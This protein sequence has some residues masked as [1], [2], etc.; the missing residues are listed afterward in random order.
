MTIHDLLLVRP[1]SDGTNCP[2]ALDHAIPEVTNNYYR[3]IWEPSNR[4]TFGRPDIGVR[5]DRDRFPIPHEDNRDNY[6]PDRPLEYWVSGLTDV[7]TL[8]SWIEA[9]PGFGPVRRVLDFGSSSGRV[10]RHWL[11]QQPA[12]ELFGAD[13]NTRSIAWGRKHLP[14]I[15][16]FNNTIVPHLPFPDG[17]FD[18]ITAYSV[19]T[20]IDLLEETWLLELRRISRPGGLVVLTNHSEVVWEAIDA[21]HFMY[22]S[23]AASRPTVPLTVTPELFRQPMPTPRLGFERLE[24]VAN[25]INMFRSRSY[26]REQWGRLFEVRD[27]LERGHLFHDLVILSAP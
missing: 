4:V 2:P 20:H 27:I 5:M 12:A 25:E 15:Y 19:F 8:T 24:G 17:Y 14:G 3:Y 6:F 23:L 16:F 22:E 1:P 9:Q 18:L 7:L 11:C 13:L 10:L 21:G 26:V